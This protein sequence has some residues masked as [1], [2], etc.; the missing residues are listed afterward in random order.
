M[1]KS[2]LVLVICVLVGGLFGGLLGE[3]LTAITPSG[4]IHNIFTQAVN[5]G[6]SPPVT[7]DLWLLKFTFGFTVKMNLLSFIGM[8]LGVFIYKQI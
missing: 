6:L 3:I 4:V 1:R 8:L 7:I 2:P 5:P